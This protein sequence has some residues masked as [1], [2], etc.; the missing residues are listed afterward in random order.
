MN[1][2]KLICQKR[3]INDIKEISE[4][5]LEGIGITE[6][7]NNFMQYIINIKLQNGIYHGYCIQLLLTFNENYP[8]KPPKIL[9]FPNQELDGRYHHHIFDDTYEKGFKKFCFDLLDNDFMNVNE[10]KTGWNPSYTISSLLL[11]VQNF[12]SEP[13][14]H[15]LPDSNQINFL[16]K[17][18]EN[19][20]KIFKDSEGNEIIH[21]WKNPFP[22]MYFQK[23]KNEIKNK[24]N[25]DKI[26]LNKIKENLTCFTLK[27]NYIDYPEI[28]LGYPI[29]RLTIARNKIELYPIPELLSYDAYI[30]QF[31][32]EQ[33]LEKYFDI[34]FKSANNEFYNAWVPIYINDE[35]YN[36]NKISILNSFSVMKFG[37]L[38]IKKYDFEPNQIFEILPIIL[39]KMI[40]GIFNNK[41]S[42]SESFII[43]YFHYI[44][45]FKKLVSEFKK[46]FDLY[47]QNILN[48]I[49]ENDYEIDKKIIPD[50]GNFMMLLFFSDIEISKKLWNCLFEE[51]FVRQMFWMFHS[52]ENESKMKKIV[53][54][55]LDNSNGNINNLLENSIENQIMNSKDNFEY[56]ENKEILNDIVNDLSKD[57]NI[58]KFYNE[59]KENKVNIKIFIK[60]ELKTNF[61]NFIDKSS[62][63][64]NKKITN[65]IVKKRGLEFILNSKPKTKKNKK[66]KNKNNENFIFNPN[67]YEN[68]K[69]E[70]LLKN[71]NSKKLLKFAYSSQRGN[72]LLL[73]TFIAKK[74]MEEKNFISELKKNYGVYINVNSFIEEM[75]QKLKEINSYSALYKFIGCDLLDNLTEKEYL[76]QS[77]VKAKNKQYI[78][79]YQN[80]NYSNNF[81][82]RTNNF[83]SRRRNVCPICGM[84]H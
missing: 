13:D 73:I 16:L 23:E 2:S 58:I 54:D 77:Y 8:T 46:E 21:T 62:E 6:Y 41:N 48:Q 60:H 57:E 52:S 71:I 74:K 11:Q 53:F 1:K 36:K 47:V 40:I 38:G 10:E 83:F 59:N 37:P 80:N 75:K 15:H 43:C 72:H 18:N 14:M 69:V 5:P 27:L 51:M 55:E 84:V 3:I 26:K 61:K 17:S 33:K 4:N 9:I 68:Y 63:N 24:K 64:L 35:H 70:N 82:R 78:K 76:I 12:L 32:K 25:E 34:P 56:C 29:V 45:L 49:K 31:E 22:K 81:Y 39:N 28:L 42:I 79:K 50:I 30:N 44:L 20:K 67:D 65:L 19:Y 66:N 7:N